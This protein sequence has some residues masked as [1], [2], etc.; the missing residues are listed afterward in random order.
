VKGTSRIK[1]G[2]LLLGRIPR[3]VG[4]V[5]S[6]D[7]DLKANP[8]SFDCDV[9]EYRLDQLPDAG[10]WMERCMAV[11]SCGLPVILTPRLKTEGGGWTKRDADRL[12]VYETA[13]KHLSAVDV[14]LRSDIVKNVAA[15]ATRWRKC[16]I[17]SYHDFKKTPPLSELM[18]VAARAQKLGTVIKIT[19][20]THTTADVETLRR[21][22]DC[23]WEKPICIM[24][25]GALGK[26][27]RTDFPVLG[28]CLTYGYLDKPAA[29]GQLSAASLVARLRKLLPA[30]D[31][32]FAARRRHR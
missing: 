20:M 28:S 6:P 24:G 19:T 18:R 32:D 7:F 21:L 30:Y 15:M 12:P 13:I 5:T 31:G 8:R 23:E 16:C 3:V 17:V 11:E 4:V 2:K 14:E 22:L 26:A 27:T 1:L 9:L 10:N 25:M 29:P